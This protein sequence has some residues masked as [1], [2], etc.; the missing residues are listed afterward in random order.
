MVTQSSTTLYRNSNTKVTQHRCSR[1]STIS[2]FS[3]VTPITRLLTVKCSC[4]MG[5]LSSLQRS[6]IG[7]YM[8]TSDCIPRPV[9]GFSF[10]YLIIVLPIHNSR[11][12]SIPFEPTRFCEVWPE[13]D[14][15]PG[16]ST[17]AFEVASSPD[18]RLLDKT[19]KVM[20]S[21]E[22]NGQ[23]LELPRCPFLICGMTRP[24]ARWFCHDSSLDVDQ[25]IPRWRRAPQKLGHRL[26]HL[27]ERDR[28][29]YHPC[30]L[31]RPSRFGDPEN[32]SSKNLLH[33]RQSSSPFQLS[34]SCFQIS[35]PTLLS[36]GMASQMV[37][38]ARASEV[39]R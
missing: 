22:L 9:S 35:L 6:A 23:L 32:P 33:P 13:G 1:R 18:L 5:K 24:G 10:L 19:R 21:E 31:H 28:A 30:H 7:L 29:P 20:V 2:I 15:H 3:L 39:L 37:T 4:F 34:R 12:T 26:Q 17:P 11:P 8:T 16:T 14:M 27:W 25:S 36:Q 38:K